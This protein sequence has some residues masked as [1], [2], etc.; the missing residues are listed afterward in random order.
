MN[1]IKR[2]S[3]LVFPSLLDEF[4][5]P[6]WNG[7]VQNFNSTIPAVNIKESETNYKLE[8]YAPG[9]K[10]EEF[11]IEV[12]QKTL[13]ISSEKQVENDNSNEKYSLKE[14]SYASFKRTFN[15]PESVDLDAIEANYENGVLNVS[16]PK[17]EETLQKSRRLI[18]IQ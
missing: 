11:N 8:F 5:R 7:G 10:K 2:N 6:D 3:S 16:L 12:D 15:L 17:R 14:Y 1:L 4:F 9:Y 13:I 18:A